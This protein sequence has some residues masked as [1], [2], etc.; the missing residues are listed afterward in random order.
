MH[1]LNDVILN[2]AT[3]VG[4]MLIRPVPE[5]I[6]NMHLYLNRPTLVKYPP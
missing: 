2:D 5:N 4:R 3:T 6:F 1:I